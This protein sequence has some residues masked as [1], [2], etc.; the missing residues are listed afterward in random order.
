ML[1]MIIVP[2]V[3]LSIMCGIADLAG[4]KGKLAGY[5][6]LY[7]ACTTILS[8]ILGI[9]LTVIIKPGS[10]VDADPTR[11]TGAQNEKAVADGLL[12]IVRNIF[13]PNIVSALFEQAST[14]RVTD[15]NG[16]VSVSTTWSGSNGP[17]PNV[18]GVIMFFATFGF[19]LGRLKQRGN[20]NAATA[21]NIFNGMNDAVM[22][23]VDLIM[24]IH[25]IGLFFL[26]SNKIMS[27]ENGAIWAAL[28]KLIAT[29]LSGIFIHACIII[30]TIYWFIT[31]KN[32]FSYALGVSQA[33]A[34][35]WAT[36]S[37]AATMPITLRN[38]ET[39]NKIDRR[40]TRFMIPVG[41]TINM[42]GTALYE[43]VAA[44]FIAQLNGMSLG[45]GKILIIAITGT[46][47]SVGAAAV[48]S[49]GLVTL[50]IVLTAVDLPLEDIAWIYTIDWFLDRFRTA[51]NVWGDSVGCGVVQHLCQDELDEE[52]KHSDLLAD[53]RSQMKFL[54]NFVCL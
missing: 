19:F 43:A 42:D 16:V 13:A 32:P 17:R 25:P 33:L 44:L 40:V 29:T 46:V 10:G 1:K 3:T 36:A 54:V 8:I 37:S 22:E 20:Q 23:L 31:K 5:G 6:M 21:L 7:Y 49:A 28:G 53:H 12:D 15:S 9:I 4:S 45:F 48:P 14:A 51:T 30:P 52:A 24:W 38:L 47:A 50:I 34:T 26:I 35:A 2:I 27:I 18:L 11:L 41:A 39:K